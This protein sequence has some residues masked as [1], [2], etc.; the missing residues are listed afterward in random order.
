MLQGWDSKGWW[1]VLW[2]LAICL[3][4]EYGGGIQMGGSTTLSSSMSTAAR[5]LTGAALSQEVRVFPVHLDKIWS[6]G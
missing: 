3:I 6:S 2:C 4:G 5:V 1:V